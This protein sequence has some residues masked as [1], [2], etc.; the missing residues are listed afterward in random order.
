M[1][2]VLGV[3]LWGGLQI[4]AHQIKGGLGEQGGKRLRVKAAA[5][6]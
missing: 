4:G 5:F 3:G 2:G 6:I 1:L